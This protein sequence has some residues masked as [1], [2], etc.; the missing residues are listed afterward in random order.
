MSLE[1]D[2]EYLKEQVSKL[3]KQLLTLVSSLRTSFGDETVADTVTLQ[4]RAESA[5]KSLAYYKKC[6]YDTNT[7]FCELAK[8]LGMKDQPITRENLLRAALSATTQ[9]KR[10]RYEKHGT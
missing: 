3:Q 4:V 6:A 9:K 2:V 1:D 7:L 10:K 8:L 5:E